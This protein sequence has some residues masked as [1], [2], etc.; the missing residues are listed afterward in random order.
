LSYNL[1]INGTK[2]AEATRFKSETRYP[3]V[4][5]RVG[6]DLW[7]VPVNK[8]ESKSNWVKTDTLL[9]IPVWVSSPAYPYEKRSYM[10][11]TVC[12]KIED[13]I[14]WYKL[15]P[16]C[17]VEFFHSYFNNVEYSIIELP[18][19]L[20][21]LDASETVS[22]SGM[23]VNMSGLNKLPEIRNTQNVKDYS[24]MFSDG[25]PRTGTEDGVD[26]FSGETDLTFDMSSINASDTSTYA[27]MIPT[28][29]KWETPIKL[30][31]VPKNIDL[32]KLFPNEIAKNNAIIVNYKE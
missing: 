32:D 17:D 30:V 6:A 22:M 28:Y 12:K 10:F 8:I 31:N 24:G 13:D 11:F 5:L 23:F 25:G 1:Y 29:I 7:Y 14:T 3:M 16:V 20:A 26:Y 15:P 19:E 27:D 2:I 18:E 4:S 9:S 21:H